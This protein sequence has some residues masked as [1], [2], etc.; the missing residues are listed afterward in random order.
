VT[1]FVRP[2]AGSLTLDSEEVSNWST[3]RRAR[4]GMRRSFQSLELF[5]DLT[6]E[7][8]LRAGADRAT[9]RS[10]IT[11]LFWPRPA[12][13][14]SAS[15]AAIVEFGLQDDLDR[16][17]SELPYGRR[18]LV[19]IART[20]ASGPSVI[21]LDEPAAGLDEVESREL[22][23][24]IRKLADHWRM[25]VLLVDHDMDLVMAAADRIVVLD[26]GA[27]IASGT[28]EEIRSDPGVRAAYLGV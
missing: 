12:P 25:G 2:A 26:F 8:N 24:L 11:D 21:M 9:R 1:G 14:P 13:M 4:H 20:V 6:V 16:L 19:G 17:P 28:P 27:V 15:V 5:E 3:T 7:A 18:R 10:W 23:G 22:V